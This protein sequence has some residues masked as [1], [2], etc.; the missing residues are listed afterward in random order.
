MPDSAKWD[1]LVEAHRRAETGPSQEPPVHEPTA[2]ILACS[3]ARVPPSVIFDQPAGSLFVVRIAGNTAS[4]AALAS[5]DYAVEKLGVDLL[6]VLGHTG[7][8]AVQAAA[9]GTCGGHLA[10]IVEP[11]CRLA[12]SMPDAEIDDLVRANVAGTI[13]DLR[14][15]SGPVGMA[16][17]N[18]QLEIRGAV[19]NLLL[20]Q[21]ETISLY[22]TTRHFGGTMTTTIIPGTD[23]IDSGQLRQLRDEDPDIRILDVRSGGEFE[24]MHIPGSYNVPLDTLGEHVRDLASVE[25][26]VVLVC[27]TG[28]RATQAHEKLIAAG[29]DTLHILEGG[30][31]SWETTGGDVVRGE[32]DKWAMDR[33]V[34][35]LAGSIA[36]AGIAASTVI[37][38]AKWL[39]G[40][41]AAGLTYSAASNTCAMG[42]VLSKLP[43]NRTDNCDIA[44]V[45]SELNRTAA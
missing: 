41:V 44:G 37:P 38:G 14:N 45:L 42:A 3:D 19:H 9:A 5:L 31:S 39:A 1:R 34:R 32:N 16:A 13:D 10:P 26:P 25:H 24:T 35:F 43:Y 6:I 36:L 11:I 30:M 27:Q 33:Q 2:A 28:G 4:P 17:R 23:T 15:H 12:G 20:G 18:G 7:C 40:G 22:Q 29:K 8:G 21:L